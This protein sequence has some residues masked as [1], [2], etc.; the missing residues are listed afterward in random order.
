LKSFV[1]LAG[2]NVLLL[3]FGNSAAIPDVIRLRSLLSQAELS[4]LVL[5]SAHMLETTA[6]RRQIIARDQKKETRHSRL[7]TA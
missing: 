3:V 4:E 7:K 6:K 2:Q 5:D 1:I